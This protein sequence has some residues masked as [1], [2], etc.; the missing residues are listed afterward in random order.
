MSIE[1]IIKAWK[2]ED[3]RNSLSSEQLENLPQNPIGSIELDDFEGTINAGA[4][5]LLQG[6]PSAYN[7]G[8]CRCTRPPEANGSCS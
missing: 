2:D 5:S 8:S 4:N 7:C 6:C 1:Q 3:Y